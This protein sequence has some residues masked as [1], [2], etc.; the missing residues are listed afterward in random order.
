MGKEREGAEVMR[1]MRMHTK[2][3]EKRNKFGISGRPLWATIPYI[4]DNTFIIDILYLEP[5]KSNTTLSL[6]I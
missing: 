6:T 4:R 1:E 3:A 2:I 5:L